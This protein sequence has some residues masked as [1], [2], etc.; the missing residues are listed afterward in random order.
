MKDR[1][2]TRSRLEPA[3][4]FLVLL[5]S[6]CRRDFRV[7]Y[8]QTLLGS[9]WAFGQP[10]AVT[11]ALVFLL[12]HAGAPPT[13]GVPYASFVFPGMV[14]WI[15]FS[16]G[17]AGAVLAVSSSLPIVT[18]VRFP[19]LVAPIS[20]C[21][22]A[23]VDFALAACL[24]PPLLLIQHSGKVPD[25]GLMAVAVVGM[26]VFGIGIGCVMGAFAVFVRDLR[27]AMPFVLQL[28]LL[29]TPV[30]YPASRLPAVLAWNPIST[31]VTAFRGALVDTPTPPASELV[32]ALC[33][34]LLV[35]L[36]GIAY[37]RRVE[38]RFADVA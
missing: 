27:Q 25:V 20:G 11:S 2:G 3:I 34:S 19:R 4:A 36:L 14:C 1:S 17:C 38:D 12:K 9:A 21:L 6:W 23:L 29:A 24:L 10:I 31:F 8:S 5:L 37:Y 30:A 26:V 28:L 18:K 15:L 16:N 7:R 33:L 22:L 13:P 32:R 35:A